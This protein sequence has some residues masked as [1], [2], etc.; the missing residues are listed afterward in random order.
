MGLADVSGLAA[1]VVGIVLIVA[2]AAKAYDGER[3]EQALGELVPA[4]PAT[5]R[6][7]VVAFEAALGVLLVSGLWPA[8]AGPVAVATLAAFSVALVVLEARGAPGCGCFGAAPNA[9]HRR[10]LARNGVL[11]GAGMLVA[12]GPGGP[13]WGDDPAR[14]G[15]QLALGAATLLLW[16]LAEAVADVPRAAERVGHEAK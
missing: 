4:A 12:L 10:G 9:S 2:A 5:A 11:L 13:A 6:W 7:V 1:A 16:R 3:F 14:A 15:A 8:V